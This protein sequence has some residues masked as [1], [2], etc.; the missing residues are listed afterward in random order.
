MESF[1]KLVFFSYT[2]CNETKLKMLIFI[3]KNQLNQTLNDKEITQ[4]L[5]NFYKILIL[6][7][8]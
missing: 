6:N 7:G 1:S 2:L 8:N 3:Q 4:K 5:H